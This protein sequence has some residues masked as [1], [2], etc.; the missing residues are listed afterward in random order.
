M[1]SASVEEI[2]TTAE[3]L[4]AKHSPWHFHLL[5]PVCLINNAVEYALIL[6]DSSAHETFVCYSARPFANVGKQLVTLLHGRQ[7]VD[8]VKPAA[9]TK[10][11][12]AVEKIIE[13]AKAITGQKILWHHHLFFPDCIYNP[14]PGKWTLTLEDPQ[15][16]YVLESV[17]N[18]E[19]QADLQLIE[20]LFYAQKKPV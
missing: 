2:V 5:T 18:T 20:P 13:R 3:E 11:S 8:Q 4:N 10:P 14:H 15:N 6:E 7:V 16:K 12:P 9:K 19:P 1:K 17:T